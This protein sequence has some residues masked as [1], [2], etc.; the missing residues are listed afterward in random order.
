MIAKRLIGMLV[1]AVVVMVVV[2]CVVVV[3][4]EDTN[5]Q[6]VDSFWSR[7]PKNRALHFSK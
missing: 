6:S 4:L 1:V 2:V 5:M 3:Y 7:D